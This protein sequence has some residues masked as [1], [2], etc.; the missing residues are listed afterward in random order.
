MIEEVFVIGLVIGV[1]LITD[2][3][4]IVMAKLLP[5]YNLTELKT[6]RWEAG[7]LPVES[8]KYLLPMQYLGFMLIFMAVEPIAVVLFILS[9]CPHINYYILLILLTM[10]LVPGILIGYREVTR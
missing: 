9:A 2:V 10:I 3:A 4:I 5:K 8:P 7:N 1:C 6:S